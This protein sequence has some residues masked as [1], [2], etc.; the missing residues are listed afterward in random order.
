[1]LKLKTYCWNH[2]SKIIFKCVN[3]TVGPIFNE[4]VAKKWNLWVH[5]QYMITV[6]CRKVNIY[7]YCLLN[8]TWTV[9]AFCQN[10]WKKKKK[11]QK[12]ETQTGSK[13]RRVSKLALS[14]QPIGHHFGHLPWK[15]GF[16]PIEFFWTSFL[17]FF[18]FFELPSFF[19][20]FPQINVCWKFFNFLFILFFPNKSV[21]IILSWFLVLSLS[22]LGYFYFVV[23]FISKLY[24][25]PC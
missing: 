1:M 9:T 20:F 21:W 16:L 24:L 17:F 14:V 2:C 13:R 12:R 18:Q 19:K 11:E 3:S 8:S 22:Y 7:G 4:K 15:G 5:K 6:C 25:L 23:I 10:A